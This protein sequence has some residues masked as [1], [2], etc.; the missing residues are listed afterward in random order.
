MRT[1]PGQVVGGWYRVTDHPAGEDVP[2]QDLR[3]GARVRIRPLELPELLTPGGP[4][5][6]EYPRYG[7]RLAERVAAVAAA[8]PDHARLLRGLEAVPED[9]L[10]W[11]VEERTAGEPLSRLAGNGPVSAYRVAEIAADLA[12]ALRALHRAGLTHG[13]LTADTVLVCEDGA[14]LLGGLLGGAAEEELCAAVGGPVPRRV[15]ETRALL[16]GP[17]AERWPIDAGAPGDCWALGCCCT[18]C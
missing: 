4:E 6:P 3:S 7:P 13:N 12:T 14:A 11:V 15:Y 1:A 18:G 2:A 16:V 5:G 17:R 9:E 8:A 10:L